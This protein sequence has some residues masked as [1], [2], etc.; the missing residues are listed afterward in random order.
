[1]KKNLVEW[2]HSSSVG[3]PHAVIMVQWIQ[4]K[5][6]MERTMDMTSHNDYDGVS[7]CAWMGSLDQ[8]NVMLTAQIYIC[9]QK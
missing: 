5:P 8:V 3:H 6:K 9:L 1:M 2:T 7:C 4:A